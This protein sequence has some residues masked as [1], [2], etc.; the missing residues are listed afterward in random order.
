MKS[1]F[2]YLLIFIL[3][4][5]ITMI[6]GST[7]GS[8]D[9]IVDKMIK[10]A[11]VEVN[12]FAPTKIS[13]T[14]ISSSGKLSSC[15]AAHMG[16]V[17]TSCW[18]LVDWTTACRCHLRRRK[19]RTQLCDHDCNEITTPNRKPD[20]ELPFICYNP[21]SWVIKSIF[22]RCRQTKAVLKEFNF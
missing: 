3:L 16:T 19:V 6:P 1:T 21:A 12:P 4:Q 10:E 18:G 14:S 13:C 7:Q 22:A 20:A 11:L 15:P 9:S 17:V 8:L 2:C 5:F